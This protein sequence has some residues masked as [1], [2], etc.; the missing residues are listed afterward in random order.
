MKG[1]IPG[2]SVLCYSKQCGFHTL[3][4]LVAGYEQVASIDVVLRLLIGCSTVCP[5][6]RNGVT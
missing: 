1:G 3:A 4:D 6:V 2:F 5:K